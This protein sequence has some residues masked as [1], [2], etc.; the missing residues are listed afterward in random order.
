[1]KAMILAAGRGQRMRPLT[2]AKPKPLLEVGGRALIDWHLAALCR[3]GVGEVVINTAWL[4][5]QVRAH[6]GD[7]SAWGVAVRYSYEGASGL[8]T[9]GGIR[10]ALHWLGKEPFWVIN[11]DVWTDFDPARLPTRPPRLAHLVV[12]ANPPHNSAGDFR[13]GNEGQLV[14]EPAGQPCTFSGIGCYHPALFR[15]TTAASFRLAPFLHQAVADGQVTATY[16]AGDWFD[17]G[18][19][20]RLSAVDAY[21]RGQAARPS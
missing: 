14:A 18:T 10:R 5:E 4:A 21:L 12:V 20:E 16:H 6:V 9:G 8:E 1:M 19:P 13:L 15:E 3:A 17:I 11:G 7:G 2:D